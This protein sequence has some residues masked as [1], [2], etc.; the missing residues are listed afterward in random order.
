MVNLKRCQRGLWY[1]YKLVCLVALS[2]LFTACTNLITS[3]PQTKQE[4][5][6]SPEP[7]VT[8]SPSEIEVGQP[9]AAEEIVPHTPALE[10]NLTPSPLFTPTVSIEAMATSQ[11]APMLQ[12]LNRLKE[13]GYLTEISG[14]YHRLYD[15][16][17]AVSQPYARNINLIDGFYPQSFAL[18]AN[19]AWSKPTVKVVD[20]DNAGCGLAFHV[21][22]DGNYEV[23]ISI[24]GIAL[25][26][27]LSYTTQYSYKSFLVDQKAYREFQAQ[28]EEEVLLVVH[29][30][31]IILLID[32]HEILNTK[33]DMLTSDLYRQGLL[34]F[35]IENGSNKGEV[36]CRW[37]NLELWELAPYT[38]E[39][40]S[41]SDLTAKP[42]VILDPQ[43]IY[44]R[45]VELYQA[46]KYEAA[47]Q[48]FDRVIQ[49]QP[50]AYVAYYARAVIFLTRGEYPRALDNIN[51]AIS[52]APD[53]AVA[54]YR[55]AQIYERIGDMVNAESDYK[56]ASEL[57]YQ[58]D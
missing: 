34:A 12:V 53:L 51:Q 15:A 58:G 24:D 57:G 21:N 16:S 30:N 20:K 40:A 13:H 25:L 43:T 37:S 44:Q 6:L 29:E 46:G 18:R 31:Q 27:R 41:S 56:K 26:R 47:L 19:I 17:D 42:T 50:K 2:V 35:M 1:L 3:P 52:L 14:T 8:I 22:T 38:A 36:A 23:K 7:P 5:I 45:G 32:G 54:Y 9:S 33:D 4:V 49:L 48:E 11:A 28:G 39:S 55:R 10:T